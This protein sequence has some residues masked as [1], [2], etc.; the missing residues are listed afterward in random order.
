[1]QKNLQKG[2]GKYRFSGFIGRGTII[3]QNYVRFYMPRY[4][5]YE[6]TNENKRQG[7]KNAKKYHEFFA[8]CQVI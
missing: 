1:M 5:V 6:G 2:V 3:F 8:S 7:N 4:R